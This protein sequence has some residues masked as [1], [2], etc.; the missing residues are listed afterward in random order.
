MHALQ[1]RKPSV[2]SCSGESASLRQMQQSLAMLSMSGSNDSMV[3]Q[4]S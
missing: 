4:P 3:T 1:E 2:A